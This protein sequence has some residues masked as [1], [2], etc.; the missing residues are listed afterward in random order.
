MPED[1]HAANRAMLNSFGSRTTVPIPSIICNDLVVQFADRYT[2][3][4]RHH[5]GSISE[6]AWMM[7]LFRAKFDF[8]AWWQIFQAE[9]GRP[10]SFVSIAIDLSS[11]FMKV[12]ICYVFL[13]HWSMLTW[14]TRLYVGCGLAAS[15]WQHFWFVMAEGILWNTLL[16]QFPIKK[17]SLGRWLLL[18]ITMPLMSF[19]NSI[20]FTVV[21]TLDCLWQITFKGELVYVC[22]PKGDGTSPDV[23]SSPHVRVGTKSQRCIVDKE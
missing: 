23:P 18:V 12:F 10:G 4:K 17:P 1:I 6:F 13:A 14:K 20:V 3:A 21:P 2:Q 7:S 9:I 8:H 15:V 5:Y 16:D 19:I 22:A 11:K